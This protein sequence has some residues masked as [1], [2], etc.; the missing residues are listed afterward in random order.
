VRARH[1]CLSGCGT[2]VRR[3]FRLFD[4]SNDKI[5]SPDEFQSALIQLRF[6]HAENA[7]VC[8]SMFEVRASSDRGG[9]VVVSWRSRA[10]AS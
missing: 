9:E 7:A 6:D 8:F 4:D 10:E 5:V 3:I 1:P 2:Q